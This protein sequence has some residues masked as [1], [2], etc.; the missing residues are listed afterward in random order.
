M[1]CFPIVWKKKDCLLLFSPSEEATGKCMHIWAVVLLVLLLTVLK[2]F[3]VNVRK[4]T[5]IQLGVSNAT[6]LT[7]SSEEVV[8]QERKAWSIS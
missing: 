4:E 7:K 5:C 8:S 3:F 2:K 6:C 1:E